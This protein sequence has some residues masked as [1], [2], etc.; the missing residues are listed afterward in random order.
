VRTH[1]NRRAAL[2]APGGTPPRGCLRCQNRH[3]GHCLFTG[4]SRR[5]PHLAPLP[6]LK[7]PAESPVM[8]VPPI[9]CDGTGYDQDGPQD[10]QQD[11]ARPDEAY[12][13]AAGLRQGTDDCAAAF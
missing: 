5:T 1:P 8:S 6:G 10:E 3:R 11:A 12:L 7:A 9:A 13:L 2:T 4:D